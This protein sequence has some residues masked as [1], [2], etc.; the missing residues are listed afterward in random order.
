M[1]NINKEIIE[2]A[3]AY[4]LEEMEKY[5]TPKKE[6]FDL[7][8][9]KGQKLAKKLK[10]DK[11]IVMLGT[12][13][14]DLKLGECLKEN[15]VSEHVERSSAVS[16][17]FLEKFDLDNATVEKIINC[18]E[19]H[20][21][22]KEFICKEAEICANADCYRFLSP[23]GIFA[24]LIL[25][26]NRDDSVDVCLKKVEEK[27]NEKWNILTLD[28]CKKETQKDYNSFKKLIDKS[29]VKK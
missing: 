6:H 3:K 12:I 17:E 16:R 13:L 19:A 4:A 29:I 1:K 25:F 23:R 8:N 28:I 2:K 10:A 20:H 7:S 9:E 22:K 26:G 15:N 5:G 11:D 24:G 14:M 27:M 21:G 18:I